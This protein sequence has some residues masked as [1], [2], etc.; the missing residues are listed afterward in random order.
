MTWMARSSPDASRPLDEPVPG[1]RSDIRTDPQS[2]FSASCGSTNCGPQGSACASCPAFPLQ[3]GPLRAPHF[4][5]A[6]RRGRTGDL[7]PA[8]RAARPYR[9]SSRAR[10]GRSTGGELRPSFDVAGQQRHSPTPRA[11][12]RHSAARCPD[13]WSGIRR[14]GMATQPALRDDHLRSRSRRKTIALLP[15]REPATAQA[16]LSGQPQIAVVARDRG[17]GCALAAQKALPQAVRGGRS[18]AFDGKRQPRLP[19]CGARNPCA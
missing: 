10:L 1:V 6:V 11:Q 16:W 18:L 9:A 19:R 12:T 4:Q 3:R 8:N 7:G 2:I 15:D 5:R 14:L 13:G 17:G